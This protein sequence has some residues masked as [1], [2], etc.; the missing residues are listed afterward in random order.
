MTKRFDVIFEGVGRSSGKMRNDISVE[1][2]AQKEI[3]LLLVAFQAT[4]LAINLT[5]L[6]APC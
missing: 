5:A 3:F 2:P 4:V 1:W 6:I